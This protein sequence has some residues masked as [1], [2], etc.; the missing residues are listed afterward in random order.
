MVGLL[1]S[2]FS[3]G[4]GENVP[5]STKLANFPLPKARWA[6]SVFHWYDHLATAFAP[7]VG[8]ENIIAHIE[9]FTKFTQQA[10]NDSWQSLSLLNTKMSLMR[11]AVLQNR[12]YLDIFIASQGGTL[13]L[14]GQNV[15][16]LLMYHLY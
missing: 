1:H 6:H 7:S 9:A 13:P 11:K 3:L 8:L 15:M 2:G 14:S 16:S 12:M 10:L 5:H 4:A